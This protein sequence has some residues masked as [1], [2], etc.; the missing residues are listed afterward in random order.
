MSASVDSVQSLT[1]STLNATDISHGMVA[2]NR[3]H[4]MYI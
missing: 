3:L 2:Y 1:L 4:A